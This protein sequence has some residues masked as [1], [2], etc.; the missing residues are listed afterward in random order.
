MLVPPVSN[1]IIISVAVPSP[2]ATLGPKQR[3]YK[4]TLIHSPIN[5][6]DVLQE[7]MSMFADKNQRDV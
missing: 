7:T 3:H 4:S 2:S 6:E 1:L 5:S